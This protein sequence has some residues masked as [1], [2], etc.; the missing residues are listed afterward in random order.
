ML[1]GSM[2]CALDPC[3]NNGTCIERPENTRK[4]DCQCQRGMKYNYNY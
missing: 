2:G 1:S 3:E 4:Y